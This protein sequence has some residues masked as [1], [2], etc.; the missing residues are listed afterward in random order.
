MRKYGVLAELLCVIS[1]VLCAIVLNGADARCGGGLLSRES[2]WFMIL[3]TPAMTGIVHGVIAFTVCLGL[4]RDNR[5]DAQPAMWPMLIQ[6][7]YIA[8]W[9]FCM[10]VPFWNFTAGFS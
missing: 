9:V 3:I 7:L 1:F 10:S 2:R 8:I 4:L 6:V 5:T